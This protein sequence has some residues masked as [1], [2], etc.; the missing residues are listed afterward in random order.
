M[1]NG[2]IENKTT[3]VLPLFYGEEIFFLLEENGGYR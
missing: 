2:F 1:K 3:S